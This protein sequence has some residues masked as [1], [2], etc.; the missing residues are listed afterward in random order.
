MVLFQ[1]LEGEKM[2]RG[3]RKRMF[4]RSVV[5]WG[6]LFSRQAGRS[7]FLYP[8]DFCCVAHWR[9]DVFVAVDTYVLRGCSILIVVEML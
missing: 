8:W 3:G 6:A 7:G 2:R 1:A 4:V 9:E 5:V